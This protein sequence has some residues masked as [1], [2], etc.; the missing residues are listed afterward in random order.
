M[1][2]PAGPVAPSGPPNTSLPRSGALDSSSTS[3]KKIKFVV[4]VAQ[5]AILNVAQYLAFNDQVI[6]IVPSWLILVFKFS[7]DLGDRFA[8][9]VG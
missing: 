3:L 5:A 8:E 4:N 2:L 9:V 1:P 6:V 7:A